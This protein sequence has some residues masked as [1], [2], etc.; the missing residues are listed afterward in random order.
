[1]G[2]PDNKCP[3]SIEIRKTPRTP[4]LISM[5]NHLS[6]GFGVKCMAFGGKLFP[7]FKVI[8]NLPIV[9]NPKVPV[10][11]SHRLGPL[12]R[13]IDDGEAAVTERDVVIG[14]KSLIVRATMLEAGGHARDKIVIRV[15]SKTEMACD[16]AHR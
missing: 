13:K 10:F 7:E 8:V 12:R 6:V 5:Q 3:H 2:I 14:I 16:S 15:A 4:L 9:D 11:I 1:M